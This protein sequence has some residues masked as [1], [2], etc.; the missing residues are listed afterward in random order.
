[1]ASDRGTVVNLGGLAEALGLDSGK[2]PVVWMDEMPFS[3]AGFREE[4]ICGRVTMDKVPEPLDLVGVYFPCLLVQESDQG[5]RRARIIG[6]PHG[7]ANDMD[8]THYCIS[9]GESIIFEIGYLRNHIHM[10]PI[11]FYKLRGSG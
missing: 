8:F 1:M 2:I 4:S 11:S 9:G 5:I 10:S 3:K 6:T 7:D